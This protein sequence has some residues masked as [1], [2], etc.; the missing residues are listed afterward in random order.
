M[1]VTIWAL[2]STILELRF[3]LLIFK[4]AIIAD[5]IMDMIKFFFFF[6]FVFYDKS[7]PSPPIAMILNLISTKE[8]EIKVAEFRNF[9]KALCVN[10]AFKR[11][12]SCLKW[13]YKLV[14]FQRDLP[15]ARPPAYLLN[16]PT[17]KGGFM[18]NPIFLI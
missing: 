13:L 5:Y 11:F 1:P 14:F 6:F 2:L 16:S 17:V 12:I 7:V 9:L 15:T 10:S 18:M 8:E 3:C 4:C